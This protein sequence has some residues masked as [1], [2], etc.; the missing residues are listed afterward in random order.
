MYVLLSGLVTGLALIAGLAFLR[1]YSRSRDRFF[2]Y[3]AAAF[4]I[5]GITQIALGYENAPEANHPASYIPRLISSL[6]ILTAIWDK[7]RSSAARHVEPPSDIEV[8]Q[9]RRIAR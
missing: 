4:I 5:F 7:N 3:F 8:Y 9:K 6:L 1:S 2:A